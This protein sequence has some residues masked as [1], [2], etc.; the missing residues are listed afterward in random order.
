MTTLNEAAEVAHKAATVATYGGSGTAVYF[1]FSPGEW[2]AIG[3][4][5][6]LF[7]AAAGFFA[8]LWFKWAHLNLAKKAVSKE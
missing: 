5:G 1:G 4:A 7:F 3:I 6:G 8:N 2:Q